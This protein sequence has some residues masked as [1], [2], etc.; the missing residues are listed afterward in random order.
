LSMLNPGSL[1]AVVGFFIG[2]LA[3]SWIVLPFILAS[4]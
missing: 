2:G 3:V 4:L 1:V